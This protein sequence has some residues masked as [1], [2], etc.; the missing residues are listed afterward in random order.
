MPSKFEMFA[1]RAF[2]EEDLERLT[3][4]ERDVLLSRR[5]NSV[6]QTAFECRMS[7]STVHRMQNSIRQKLEL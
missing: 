3:S 7:K 2:T 5:K 1:A 6:I 4:D